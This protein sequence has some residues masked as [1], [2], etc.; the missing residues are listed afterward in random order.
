MPTYSGG[1]GVLA[2]DTI[3]SSADL[4]VPVVAVTLIY[5]KGYFKQEIDEEGRQHELPY[6]WNPR[7]FM[8]LRPQSIEV[9]IEGRPVKVQAWEYRVRG[10]TGYTVPVFFLDTDLEGNSKYDRSL[11]YHLYGGGHHP[12]AH[13]GGP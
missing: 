1:L 7:K 6:E 12:H 9:K 8:K 5:K 10:A 13:S 4:K 11:V 3:K 2:G